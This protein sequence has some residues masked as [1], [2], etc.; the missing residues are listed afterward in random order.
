MVDL[1]GIFPPLVTPFKNEELALDMLKNNVQRYQTFALRGYVVLGSN[2]ER[3]MLN[4]KESLQ[5]IET[6]AENAGEN[7]LVIF[8]AGEE[9]VQG[10]VRF[11]KNAARVGG[12]AALLITPHYYRSQMKPEVIFNFYTQVAEA[13]PVPIVIYN[14]PAN[15]G[16]EVPLE[17]V[18]RLAEH[19]NIIGMKD[20]SGNLT[21]QQSIL[22][23]NLPN[24]QL[25]TGTANTLMSSLVV[26]AV[27]G[28]L[29]LANILPAQ[30]IQIYEW[31]KAG[32]F[33]K[34]RHL[35]LQIV[36]LNKMI[37]AIFGIGG[38][39]FAMNHLGL[40]GGETRSPLPA[41]DEPAR[42]NILGEL[43]RLGITSV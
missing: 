11:L 18:T 34:A 41:P 36:P 33:E 8:G 7:K 17:V 16:L 22:G 26:G 30:C 3:V 15:T 1:A 38:L 10:T 9:S 19:P 42:K 39:K 14:V 5:V 31:V 13:S 28:I 21:Y 35:Q 29:A 43:Q 6:V 2:G 40:Q 25:L 4:E 20:S 24:F 12:Q 23:R 32:E 37:T 27:G